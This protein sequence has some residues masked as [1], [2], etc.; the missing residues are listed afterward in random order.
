M[1]GQL[2]SPETTHYHPLVSSR[3]LNCYDAEGLTRHV[4]VK[5]IQAPSADYLVHE[6]WR[7]IQKRPAFTNGQIVNEIRRNHVSAVEIRKS[8]LV[9]PV[10]DVRWR[11]SASRGQTAARRCADRIHRLIVNGLA[12][13]V[14]QAEQQPVAEPFAHGQLQGVIVGVAAV[15]QSPVRAG[16]R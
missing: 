14:G 13:R 15:Q 12:E 8:A 16:R 5:P 9:T 3:G 2:S 10:A 1:F 4:S 11:P 6:S 7:R